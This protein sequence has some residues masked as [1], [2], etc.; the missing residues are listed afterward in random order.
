MRFARRIAAVAIAMSTTS[1]L[2][3]LTVAAQTP[4]PKA[5]APSEQLIGTVAAVDPR[6]RTFDLLT[7]VGHALRVRR[8]HMPTGLAIRALRAESPLSA[9]K[10]GT[11]VRVEGTS[12]RTGTDASSVEQ[13]MAPQ[14]PGTR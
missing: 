1:V 12:S 8:V 13:L 11:I 7:G 10:P 5:V 3:Y 9:L 2:V 14:S 6:A 4:A